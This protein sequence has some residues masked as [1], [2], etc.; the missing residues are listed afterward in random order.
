MRRE[1]HRY[2]WDDDDIALLK[3][4]FHR[5]TYDELATLLKVSECTVRHKAAELGMKRSAGRTLCVWTDE[6]IE[7]LRSHYDTDTLW[8]IS[9]AVG[10]SCPTVKTKAVQLGLKRPPTYD[11]NGFARRYVKNYKHNYE[12]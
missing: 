6:K 3:E 12:T 8:D 7:Y 11:R 9:Q 2:V 1:K 4:N 10:F 5:M